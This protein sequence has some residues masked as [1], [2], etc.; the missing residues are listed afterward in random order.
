MRDKEDKIVTVPICSLK[1]EYLEPWQEIYDR[2][3]LP[4]EEVPE[5]EWDKVEKK[6]VA[7]KQ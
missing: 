3:H 2:L 1:P 5:E 4:I 6:L 7:E